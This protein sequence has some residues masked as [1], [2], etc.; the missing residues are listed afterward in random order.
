MLSLFL[1]QAP[2][3]PFITHSLLLHL[4]PY[5]RFFRTFKLHERHADRPPL[6]L[7]LR[8]HTPTAKALY[9]QGLARIAINED[10]EAE[11]ALAQ[12]HALVKDDRAI[13]AELEKVRARLRGK[14]EKEKRAFKKLFE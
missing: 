13:L 3:L 2:S 11:E 6:P 12:A 7:P 8:L 1:R 10:E 9:R 4:P 5:S 14:R